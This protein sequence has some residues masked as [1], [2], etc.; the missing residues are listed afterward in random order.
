MTQ[1]D[2][3]KIPI[4]KSRVIFSTRLVVLSISES[5]LRG[6]LRLEF[7][8]IIELLIEFFC[9]KNREDLKVD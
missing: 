1:R 4:Q 5:C 9:D 6:R 2:N 3:E 7:R 8:A